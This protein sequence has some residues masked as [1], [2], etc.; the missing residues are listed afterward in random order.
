MGPRLFRRGNVDFGRRRPAWLVIPSMGP[1]LFRRGN[2]NV[3]VGSQ[4]GNVPSMGP[5]LFRRGNKSFEDKSFSLGIPSSEGIHK[6]EFTT[7]SGEKWML[8]C[9]GRI[10]K[11]LTF[12]R[13]GI[14]Y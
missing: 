8:F 9:W 12:N 4:C 5:R 7:L 13:K 14:Y 1:R 6:G 3:D 11:Y 10:G 2:D